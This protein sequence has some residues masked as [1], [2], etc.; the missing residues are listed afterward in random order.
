MAA[1]SVCV[2]R[3]SCSCFLPLWE[4]LQD[5]QVGLTQ[6]TFKLLLLPWV[7]VCEIFLCPLRVESISH[8]PPSL[9][10][11]SRAGLQI[12]MFWGL[13]FPVQDP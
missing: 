1:T 5:K 9:P 6:I 10:E 11:E 4:S 8:S 12:Q 3:V 13:I 7:Q 2:P